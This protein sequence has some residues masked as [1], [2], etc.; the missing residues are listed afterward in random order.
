MPP[1]WNFVR[2][3]PWLRA[4]LL[5]LLVSYGEVTTQ[6]CLPLGSRVL[7]A[8][9]G[10]GLCPSCSLSVESSLHAFQDC[11]DAVEALHLGGFSDAVIFS[12]TSSTFDWLVESAGLLS[13]SEFA[14]LV[15]LLWNMWNR[16]NRLVHDSHLQPVWATVMTAMLLHEDFLSAKDSARRPSSG[17]VFSSGVWSPPPSGTVAISVDGAFAPDHGT[18]IGVVARDSTGTV[19][20]GMAQH[21]LGLSSSISTEI[22]VI[23]VGLQ[24]ADEHGWDRIVLE[25]NCTTVVNQL[26]KRAGPLSYFSPFVEYHLKACG[27]PGLLL[28]FS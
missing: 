15:I 2:A 3:F 8:G 5:N 16:R 13:R 17:P 18:G 12:S 26:N 27:S 21:S 4:V 14:K 23:H 19:H 10:P 7:A 20:R 9:L 11:Q 1:C 25:S 28:F 6:D 24:L 22:A